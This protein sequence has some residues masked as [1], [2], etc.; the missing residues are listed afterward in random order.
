MFLYHLEMQTSSTSPV[1]SISKPPMFERQH[2]TDIEH[3]KALKNWIYS[4]QT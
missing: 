1:K 3:L 2:H 4:T